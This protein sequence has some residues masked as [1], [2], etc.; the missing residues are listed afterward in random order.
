LTVWLA[1]LKKKNTFTK[2]PMYFMF[3]VTLAALFMLFLN[4]L[5]YSNNITLSIISLLLFIL[6]IVLAIEA[7][8]AVRKTHLIEKTIKS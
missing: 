5:I 2:I 7:Y 8:N 1:H 4:N 3:A 6:A